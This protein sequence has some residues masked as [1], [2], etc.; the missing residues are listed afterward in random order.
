M[1]HR[2]VGTGEVAVPPYGD[3]VEVHPPA[4]VQRQAVANNEGR[5]QPAAVI[6]TNQGEIPQSYLDGALLGHPQN[7]DPHEYS[8]SPAASR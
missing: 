1:T 4:A 6:H 2:Y 3:S 7:L 8:P 5:G